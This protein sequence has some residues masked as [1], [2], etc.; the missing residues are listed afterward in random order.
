[1]TSFCRAK[2][3]QLL[4]SPLLFTTLVAPLGPPHGGLKL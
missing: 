2:Q 3:N 1:M 4:N